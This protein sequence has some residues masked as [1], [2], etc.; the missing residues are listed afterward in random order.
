MWNIPLPTLLITVYFTTVLSLCQRDPGCRLSPWAFW[1]TLCVF[2]TTIMT[3]I[4]P[5]KYSF[6]S[7]FHSPPLSLTLMGSLWAITIKFSYSASQQRKL[8]CRSWQPG[9][10]W[11][12]RGTAGRSNRG[13]GRMAA[14]EAHSCLLARPYSSRRSLCRWPSCHQ[15]ANTKQ[16]HERL[17]RAALS[18]VSVLFFSLSTSVA[19]LVLR[20]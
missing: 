2:Q 20:L 14:E 9:L 16:R 15:A 8:L 19:L 18:A 7:Q 6:Q 1:I 3:S 13:E 4:F 10:C 17:S 12:H 11:P 5:P